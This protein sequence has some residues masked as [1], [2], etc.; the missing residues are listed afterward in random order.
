MTVFNFAVFVIAAYLL[1]KIIFTLSKRLFAV[2]KLYELKKETGARVVFL[3]SPIFSLITESPK[4]DVVVEIG[5]TVYLIRFINGISGQRFVHFASEEYF[6]SF[7][8]NR[9][10]LGG[11]VKI[12]ARYRVTEHK[13]YITTSSHKVTVLPKLQIPEEY[14]E[15][16]E[17]DG[18]KV[19]PVY[20][21]N[22]APCSV[23][24]VTEEKTSI[25]V[26]FTGDE[27]YGVKIFT[28]STFKNYAERMKREEESD[29]DKLF[30]E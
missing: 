11:K 20:I 7:L 27:F 5:K 21:F 30:Y 29:T 12:R 14:R 1:Y 2:I 26:A 18:R 9:F 16:S 24:Y 6:V 13:G 17:F 10:T 8:K 4:P 19:V 3:R 15:I 22:P 25:K 28:S 23:S